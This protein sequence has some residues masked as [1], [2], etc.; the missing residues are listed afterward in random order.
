MSVKNEEENY[1]IGRQPILN[2]NEELIAYELLFRSAA[3]RNRAE[4]SD[5]THASASVILNTLSS[6]GLEQIVGKSRAFINL[7]QKMF[8]GDTIELLP[9]SRVVLEIL[10]SAK[11]S[12]Q[13][14]RRCRELKDSGFTLALDDHS[15]NPLYEELYQIV[16]IIKIDLIQTPQKSLE[17]M[18]RHFRNYPVKLLAEKVET[19]E[20]YQHCYHL[21]FEF[22]QGYFFA[23][24]TL[25]EKRRIDEASTTLLKLV[26]LIISDSEIDEIERTFR[27]SPGLTYK[28]LLLVNSVS[29]GF[30]EQIETVRHAITL[31]GRQRLKR[32][33]QLALFVSDKQPGMENPL[34]DLA[35]SR[36][37]F[38]EP[39]A[40][41]HP[42]LK[43][44]PESP[45]QAF[46]I[47]ILSLLEA[48]YSI[49]LDEVVS[50]LNLPHD[51][52]EALLTKSGT[53][54]TI[55]ELAELFERSFNK[56][57]LEQFQKAGFSQDHVIEAVKKSQ[58]WQKA[59]A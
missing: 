7:D 56:M 43:N 36:A 52:K 35:G 28:L 19:R 44:K 14:I 23:K 38:M 50:S 39:L 32:W 34:V 22:F 20:A 33:V 18:V 40:F 24:P 58:D 46:M 29:L 59:F 5:V 54:G 6:F 11:I 1:L 55:L 49:S 8:M 21:G 41:R 47:G 17:E 48:I 25:M 12:P 37:T 30:R 26:H 15:F 2:R 4:F 9:K 53:L 31:L 13:L 10:E 3:S 42:L 51:F 45:D 27:A 57:T 16:D